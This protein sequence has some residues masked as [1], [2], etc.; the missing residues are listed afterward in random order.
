MIQKIKNALKTEYAKMG[1]GDKAFDGVA[2]FLVKTITKD[3]EIDGVIKS[4]DTKNLLKAFQGETD[5]LR[6]RAAQLEKDFNAYKQSHPEEQGKP[7]EQGKPN[8]QNDEPE[9]AR[10]LREQNE[11]LVERLN[12]QDMARKHEAVLASVK[13]R[14]EKEGCTNKGI[15]NATLK[16]FSMGE[17]ETEDAAVERLKADYQASFKDTFGDGPVPPIGGNV[18]GDDP[19]NAANAK[20]AFLREQGL[21]PTEKK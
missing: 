3:D 1:L 7:G 12:A 5:S 8:E 6:N 19:K 14:L 9:W 13:S 21:L 15:L 11:A 16:G 4:E 20:N 10:K 18:F 2:S 17:K